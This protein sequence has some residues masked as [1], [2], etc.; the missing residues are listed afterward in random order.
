MGFDYSL[1]ARH[2]TALEDKC[3]TCHHVWDEA[4][5]KLKYEKGKEE[6]CRACHGAEDDGRKL[7]LA[8][9]S[10]RG[11]VSCHFERAATELEA[12]PVLCVGCHDQEHQQ[13]YEVL[14]EVPR[15]LRGQADTSWVTAEGSK[16]PS[17]AFDHKGHEPRTTFCSDCHHSRLQLCD[18]CHTL[19]GAADGAGVTTAQSFHLE[20]SS[21]SCVGCHAAFAAE[22]KQ[23]AGCHSTLTAVPAD[24]ACAVCHK[25]P[26]AGTAAIETPPQLGAPSLESLPAFSDDYPETVVIDLLVDHYEAS[27][28][29]HAKI[30]GALDA[31]TRESTLAATF[32]GDVKTLCS[33]C[34]HHT[35]IEMRPPPCSS[36]HG[37]TADATSDRP[38]LKVAYHRQCVGCHVQMGIA[39]QGCTDCHASKEDQS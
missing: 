9:A 24:R 34:H 3:E 16:S 19:T 1:H 38:D 28:L 11:C 37:A 5:E 35:P 33:G 26:P 10:H 18:K 15:L 14:A 39:K 6:G 25:G 27:T 29:P 21:H 4:A 23:C 22:R 30:V 2:A 8:N 13:A 7:S 32:H 36:C 17:V 20:S 12:G 31:G